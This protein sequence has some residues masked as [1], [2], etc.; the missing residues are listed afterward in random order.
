VDINFKDK[1]T[2]ETILVVGRN[3]GCGSSREQAVITLKESGVK[4]VV[5][6]SAARIWYR[7]AINLALPVIICQDLVKK[8]EDGDELSIDLKSGR[9]KNSSSGNDFEGEPVSDFILDIFDHGGMKEK[10]KKDSSRLNK[11]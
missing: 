6:S 4:A 10:M 9:I 1:I 8:I 2:P 3:F 11:T 7:N 5:A